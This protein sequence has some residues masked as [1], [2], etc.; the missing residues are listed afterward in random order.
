MNCVHP[1]C[2]VQTELWS[3]S[4]RSRVENLG[5]TCMERRKYTLLFS[6][7]EVLQQQQPYQHVDRVIMNN[8]HLSGLES[9]QE[10]D[11]EGAFPPVLG[12]GADLKGHHMQGSFVSDHQHR[13]IGPL[14]QL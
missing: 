6:E 13:I 10:H 14:R 7:S 5:C 4:G 11:K 8:P 12:G 3:E 1:E 9:K 2:R